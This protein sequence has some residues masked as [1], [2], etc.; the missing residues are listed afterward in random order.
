MS[1]AAWLS[2]CLI[3]EGPQ[4]LKK[5]MALETL[6]SHGSPTTSRRL[7]QRIQSFRSATPGSSSSPNSTL[8]AADIDAVKAFISRKVDKFRRPY[9][10]NLV[11]QERQCV[12][13]GTVNPATPIS[14]TKPAMSDFGHCGARRSISTRYAWIATQL[15]AEAVHRYLAGEKWYLIEEGAQEAALDEQGKRIFE[16]VWQPLVDNYLQNEVAPRKNSPTGA[17]MSKWVTLA[18]VMRHAVGIET[19][20]MGIVA[21]Q[22]HVARCLRRAG[23]VRYRESEPPRPWRYRLPKDNLD[24]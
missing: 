16:D 7:A 12:L 22:K 9:G 23:W 21:D 3:L 18:E 5:S 17:T 14:V 8:N 19:S 1:L 6:G 24:A 2:M 13:A 10:E 15:F 4:D 11:E 20:R